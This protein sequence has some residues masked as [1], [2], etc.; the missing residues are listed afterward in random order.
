MDSNVSATHM[1]SA[2]KQSRQKEALRINRPNV[3][4]FVLQSQRMKSTNQ[5]KPGLSFRKMLSPEQSVVW[6]RGPMN[7][8][9]ESGGP[10]R[11]SMRSTP[12]TTQPRTLQHN[13][14]KHLPDRQGR[15]QKSNVPRLTCREKPRR[16]ATR[17]APGLRLP[18]LFQNPLL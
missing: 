15:S 13:K 2:P 5:R 14:L 9:S 12:R 18:P 4:Q 3:P 1:G 7:D 10:V 16:A 17:P 11:S 6:S 8:V